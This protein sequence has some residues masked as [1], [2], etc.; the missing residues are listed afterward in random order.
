[1]MNVGRV[2]DSHSGP[3]ETVVISVIVFSL[4]LQLSHNSNN[5]EAVAMLF[6]SRDG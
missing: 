4:R 5:S 6:D 3:I 1:M 2:H